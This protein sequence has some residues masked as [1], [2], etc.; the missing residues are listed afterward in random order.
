MSGLAA[1]I[2]AGAAAASVALI[3]QVFY[4]LDVGRDAAYQWLISVHDL[5]GGGLEAT[6]PLPAWYIPPLQ[7]V[8]GVFPW[9]YAPLAGQYL[10]LAVIAAAWLLRARRR[11][12]AQGNGLVMLALALIAAALLLSFSR[13]AWIGAGVGLLV[14][15][16]R[17]RAVQAALALGLLA[18]AMFLIDVPGRDVTFGEYLLL[19]GDSSTTSTS[20]RLSLWADG[21]R[22]VVEVPLTGIGP[23]S[24]STLL[25]DPAHPVFYAHSMLLDFIVEVGILGAGCAVWLVGSALQR[26]WSRRLE[27][28]FALL[29]A[30]VVANLFDDVLYFPRNGILLAVAFALIAAPFSDAEQ[31]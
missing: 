1:A 16:L 9:M 29:T 22:R 4:G 7:F 6:A 11:E 12:G 14:L 19:S 21:L 2:V 23:G 24:Y 30:F 8:R 15:G 26:A 28:P 17:W 13:Q 20:Q 31:T 10:M 18:V 25:N 5:F 27:L 3:A